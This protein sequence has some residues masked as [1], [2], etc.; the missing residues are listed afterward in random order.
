MTAPRDTGHRL[1]LAFVCAAVIVGSAEAAFALMSMA[2]VHVGQA[3]EVIA[4]GAIVLAFVLLAITA[5]FT[6]DR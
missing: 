1:I 4:G 2:S 6:R 3:V 5:A